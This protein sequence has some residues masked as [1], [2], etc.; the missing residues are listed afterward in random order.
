MFFKP[1]ILSLL[2]GAFVISGLVM[3][4]SVFGWQIL[5]YWDLQSGSERQIRLEKQTYLISALMTYAFVYQLL[6]FFLFIYTV[7]RLHPYFVGAM[8]A[9]GSLQVN[10]W[11]YPVML[12][13][14]VNFF[15]AGGWLILNHI[16][17]QGYDYPLVRFKYG[18]LLAIMP[19]ILCETL[20]LLAYFAGLQPELITSCCGSLFTASGQGVA[21]ELVF[22]SHPAILGLFLLFLLLT[23]FTGWRFSRTGTGGYGFSLLARGTFV[24]AK[25]TSSFSRSI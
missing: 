19:F 14:L 2:L 20:F 9:A 15:L 11:G 24:L 3:V 6:S 17:N 22:T 16:D 12:A 18:L 10:R 4:S 21:G 25:A 5:R 13:K 1:A 8:C 23:F 7:D